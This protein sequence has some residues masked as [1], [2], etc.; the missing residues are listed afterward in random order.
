MLVD[1]A[2]TAIENFTD[3]VKESLEDEGSNSNNMSSNWTTAI[4][5]DAI[6]STVTIGEGING[7]DSSSST[8][9]GTDKDDA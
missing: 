7:D 9:D 4:A 5:S 1:A 2:G 6:T 3:A 8:A